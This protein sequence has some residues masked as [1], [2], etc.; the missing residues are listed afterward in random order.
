MLSLVEK[1]PFFDRCIFLLVLIVY[2]IEIITLE[3]IFN[4]EL[5]IVVSKM[6]HRLVLKFKYQQPRQLLMQYAYSKSTKQKA[7][8]VKIIRG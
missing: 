5:K 1:F 3:A 2:N 4:T 7:H 6:L 8:I